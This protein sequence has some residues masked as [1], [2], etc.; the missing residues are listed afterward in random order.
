L[1]GFEELHSYSTKDILEQS[2]SSKKTGIRD[3]SPKNGHAL[4]KVVVIKV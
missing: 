1:E 3:K 4:D 2:P